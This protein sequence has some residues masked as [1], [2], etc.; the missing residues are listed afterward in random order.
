[1]GGITK[2]PGRL[3][4]TEL[5]VMREIWGMAAP[6]TV[7]GVLEIF[8]VRRGWKTSTLST[9]MDRLI[10]KGYLTKTLHGKANIY[11]PLFSEEEHKEYETKL[12]LN[13]VHGGSVKSFIAALSDTTLSPDEIAEIRKW[14]FQ[15][16]GEGK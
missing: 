10:E 7:S 9:I 13:D 11:K 1:M 12:F 6:V 3:S 16:A 15:K 14:F 5:E 8:S 4:E 2:G